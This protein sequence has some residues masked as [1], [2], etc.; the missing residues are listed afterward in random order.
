MRE[1]LWAGRVRESA[2]HREVIRAPGAFAVERSGTWVAS[3]GLPSP[4]AAQHTAAWSVS[5][6]ARRTIAFALSF[7]HATILERKKFGVGNLPGARSG[8]GWNMV[9]GCVMDLGN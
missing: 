5:P 4:P 3:G 2:P 9:S 8:I 6:A 1:P 7:F